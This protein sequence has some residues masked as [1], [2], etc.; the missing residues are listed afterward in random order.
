[1]NWLEEISKESDRPNETLSFQEYMELLRSMH[2]VNVVPHI[3]I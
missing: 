1:M 3:F 2:L